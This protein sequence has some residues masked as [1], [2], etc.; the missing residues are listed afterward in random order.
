MHPETGVYPVETL[1]LPPRAPVANAKRV[2]IQWLRA[3][4]ASEVVIWHSDLIAKHFSPGRI[5]ES[6]YLFYGGIGV[7]LF[8]IVSGY[9]ICMTYP[10]YRSA[11]AYL[12]S[13]VLRIYPLYFL[14][15]CLVVLAFILNPEWHLSNFELTAPSLLASVLILP[16]QGFPILGVGWTLEHEMIFYVSVFFLLLLPS[17]RSENAKRAWAFILCAAG[18]TGLLLGTGASRAIWDYHLIS[19]YLVAFGFGWL[20]RTLEDDPSIVRRGIAAA[21]FL[22][23][24]LIGALG[25][26]PAEWAMAQRI[27]IAAIVFL[28]FFGLKFWLSADSRLGRAMTLIGD[29]SFSVYLSHWFVLSILGKIFG[30]IGLPP[31]A[32]LPIRIVGL[33]LCTVVGI[34]CFQLLEQPLDRFLRGRNPK[35]ATVQDHR[36]TQAAER[37][38]QSFADVSLRAQATTVERPP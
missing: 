15:T 16:Q 38:G 3:L 17:A 9:I 32:D 24:F 26:G 20:V 27:A 7:E 37:G 23:L 28:F 10:R 21:A 31:E 22:L 5:Q 36:T 6:G 19:P 8:F 25:S 34:L 2:D 12:A 14:F 35:A 1:W 33:A 18:T 13:R 30:R 11:G 29:A 4:A